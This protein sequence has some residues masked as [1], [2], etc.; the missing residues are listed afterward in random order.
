MQTHSYKSFVCF[1]RFAFQFHFVLSTAFLVGIC[2]PLSSPEPDGFDNYN[3]Q[4][5]NNEKE[6]QAHN[7]Q[8]QDV[9]NMSTND[10]LHNC[11]VRAAGALFERS[12]TKS[13]CITV[14]PKLFGTQQ[15]ANFRLTT[16]IGKFLEPN[17]ARLLLNYCYRKI[18]GAQ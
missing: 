14:M 4:N 6:L 13:F 16:C 12:T 8:Q 10:M 5:T 1:G 11:A 15:D 7:L 2:G 9:S 18:F 3:N 17:K